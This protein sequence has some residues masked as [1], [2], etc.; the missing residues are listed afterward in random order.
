MAFDGNKIKLNKI[1]LNKTKL[2]KNK[3][4]TSSG[5]SPNNDRAS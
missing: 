1:K 4:V 2:N 3:P 5:G